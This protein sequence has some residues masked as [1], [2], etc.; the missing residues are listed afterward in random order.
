MD[1]IIQDV[2]VGLTH[3]FNN[4]S[5]MVFPQYRTID[6]LRV[7]EQESKILFAHEFLKR[8]IRF[9]IEAP[10][11]SAHIQTGTTPKSARF[12]LV[13]YKEKSFDFA[14]AIELK[15]HNAPA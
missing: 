1:S 11:K 5:A 6:E 3:G 9:A 15:A 10:T 13:T 4:Q 12:D 14:W 2:A 8:N 7:S